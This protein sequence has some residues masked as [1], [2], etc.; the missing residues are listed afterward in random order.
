MGWRGFG[1]VHHS[2]TIFCRAAPNPNLTIRNFC[3]AECPLHSATRT[4]RQS[5][6]VRQC[7]RMRA[8]MLRAATRSSVRL[9]VSTALMRGCLSLLQVSCG[10]HLQSEVFIHF[11]AIAQ[12]V[13]VAVVCAGAAAAASE[14]RAPPLLEPAHLQ[15]GLQDTPLGEVLARWKKLR[16][17]RLGWE[18][19][20][21]GSMGWGRMMRGGGEGWVRTNLLL[22]L[23]LM[24]YG[25]EKVANRD[26]KA[27]RDRKRP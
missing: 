16:I 9:C 4:H 14:L 17:V 2:R 10:L 6:S 1:F 15:L 26:T 23:L 24:L 13:A 12:H 8:P 5:E 18:I 25:D 11:K 22:L 7:E 21:C 3:I 27:R 20:V 19:A